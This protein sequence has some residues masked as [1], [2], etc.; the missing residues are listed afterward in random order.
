MSP[1][2]AIL[3]VVFLSL[4]NSRNQR[5]ERKQKEQQ[6][7]AHCHSRLLTTALTH[8][9]IRYQEQSATLVKQNTKSCCSRKK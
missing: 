8:A 3:K 7:T 5:L 2:N 4:K 1:K 6:K 9:E